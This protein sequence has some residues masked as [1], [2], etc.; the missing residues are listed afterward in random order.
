MAAT[1]ALKLKDTKPRKVA[2]A[3]QGGGSHTAFTAGVL[4]WILRETDDEIVGFSGTSGGAICALLAW[5]GLVVRQDRKQAIALLEAF[6]AENSANAVGDRLLN[7]WLVEA[8]RLRGPVALPEVSPYQYP[9]WGQDRLKGMLEHLVDFEEVQK[10]RPASPML[11]VGAVNVQTGE[12]TRFKA[13]GKASQTEE[14]QYQPITVEAMLASAAVPPLF[15]AVPI[16]GSL[17][18]D[19]L[20]SQNPPIRDL[21]DAR[22]DEIWVIQVNPQKRKTEP[23]SIA[24]IQDRRNELSGNLSLN[25]EIFFIER[26]NQWVGKGLMAAGKH[27][28]IPVRRIE[29]E[30]DLDYPSKLDRSPAFIQ[31]LMAYGEEQAK[32]F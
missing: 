13:G 6:W 7:A 19:G 5:Y 26:V 31:D 10:P 8:A 3:C 16:G 1:P 29:M 24:E 22:P 21:P 25:Q 18:W 23:R 12:F 15:R 20:F 14:K 28:V 9:P 2:I 27:Q 17:Y 11:L 30:R 4:R 32:S